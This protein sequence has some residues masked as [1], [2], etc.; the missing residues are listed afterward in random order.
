MDCPLWMLWSMECSNYGVN[1]K[2]KGP[3]D[4]ETGGTNMDVDG[5]AGI[6]VGAEE[7]GILED[8]GASNL[9]PLVLRGPLKVIERSSRFQ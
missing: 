5:A 9:F 1:I 3:A 2:S 8:G 7:G 6:A 4:K